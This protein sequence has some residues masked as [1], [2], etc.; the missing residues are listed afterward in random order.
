MNQEMVAK[1]N[2]KN[3]L[4]FIKNLE[5]F[6]YNIIEEELYFQ[7]L[8]QDN[9]VENNSNRSNPFVRNLEVSCNC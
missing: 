3:C 5:R 9:Q 7:Q 8:N 4:Q 2:W 6:R 1:P